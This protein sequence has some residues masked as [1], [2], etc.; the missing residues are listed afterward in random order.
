ML[1]YLIHLIKARKAAALVRYAEIVDTTE[2]P[3]LNP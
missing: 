1:Q 2:L 3:P